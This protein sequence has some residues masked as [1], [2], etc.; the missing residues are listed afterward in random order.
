MFLRC[1]TLQKFLMNDEVAELTVMRKTV[2]SLKYDGKEK[3][4]SSDMEIENFEDLNCTKNKPRTS[5][6]QTIGIRVSDVT[7]KWSEDLNENALTNVSLDVKPGGLVAI[8]G[9]VGSGKVS[10]FFLSE[11]RSLY[12]TSD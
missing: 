5:E 2:R 8:I 12:L 6:T 4:A 1:L 11:I 10:L 3:L 7:A 9:P